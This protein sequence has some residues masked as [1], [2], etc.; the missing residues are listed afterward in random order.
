MRNRKAYILILTVLLSA[1]FIYSCREIELV[2]P[3]EYEI[4]YNDYPAP[5]SKIPLTIWIS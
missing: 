2:V 1:L 5:D 4:I 3:T